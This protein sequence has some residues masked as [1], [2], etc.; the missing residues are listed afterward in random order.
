MA[1]HL[2]VGSRGWIGGGTG[3]KRASK[4]ASS[5]VL[6]SLRHN[7]LKQQQQLRTTFNHVNLWRAFPIQARHPHYERNKN[8]LGRWNKLWVKPR[9]IE[10]FVSGAEG[11]GWLRQSEIESVEA[12]ER[13]GSW[14]VLICSWPG[15]Y[16]NTHGDV[17]IKHNICIPLH[18]QRFY[19][20]KFKNSISGAILGIT[21]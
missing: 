20:G 2:H 14:Q 3:Q 7:L 9:C 1:L 8:S 4:P 21:A 10:A 13:Q 19:T 11:S 15:T 18:L 17:W 5:D 6:P 12:T 16:A